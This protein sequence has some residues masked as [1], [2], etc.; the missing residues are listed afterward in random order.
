MAAKK[1]KYTKRSP[2]WQKQ[3]TA[4]SATPTSRVRYAIVD[5]DGDLHTEFVVDTE[6]GV[7]RNALHKLADAQ[8]DGDFKPYR[9]RRIEERWQDVTP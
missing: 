4:K 1:R 8:R 6:D 7:R 9:L 5:R 3:E 2:K